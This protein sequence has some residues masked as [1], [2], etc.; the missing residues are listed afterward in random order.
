MIILLTIQLRALKQYH[1]QVQRNE[2]HLLGT[3]FLQ[4]ISVWDNNGHL[5]YSYTYFTVISV[6]VNSDSDYYNS[7]YVRI[8]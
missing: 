1:F 2:D 5:P 8:Y 6:T 3:T 4:E 7:F